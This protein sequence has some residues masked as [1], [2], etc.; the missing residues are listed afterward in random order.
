MLW[1]TSKTCVRHS[2]ITGGV[3]VLLRHLNEFMRRNR[4]MPLTLGEFVAL[5]RQENLEVREV[6]GTLMVVGFGRREDLLGCRD[7]IVGVKQP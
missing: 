6:A 7:L 4:Q 2:R 3:A 1:M 5:L